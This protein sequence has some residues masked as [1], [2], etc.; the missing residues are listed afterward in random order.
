MMRFTSLLS[1]AAALAGTQAPQLIGSWQADTPLP[2]G[3]VQTFRFEQGGHFTL[4]MSVS[5]DGQYAVAR[6]RIVETVL[7]P[8]T[9][10]PHTDTTSFRISGDSLVVGTAATAGGT[11]T[12]HRVTPAVAGASPLVGDWVINVPNGAT[13]NYTFTRDGIVHVRARVAEEHGDYT[14]HGD[15]LQLSSNRTFQVPATAIVT[16][17]GASL[18]LAPP[19]GTQAAARHFHRVT[20]TR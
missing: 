18:T 17:Q 3:V 10:M 6:D 7:V 5:L 20:D 14:L 16:Q 12:L 13:A 4:T 15:T 9:A 2:N 1:L 19:A 11:R 8:G